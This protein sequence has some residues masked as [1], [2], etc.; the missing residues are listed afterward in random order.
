[1]RD[2]ERSIEALYDIFYKDFVTALEKVRYQGDIKERCQ[3]EEWVPEPEDT[4]EY[5]RKLESKI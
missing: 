4:L 5:Q 1:M 2:K 3:N